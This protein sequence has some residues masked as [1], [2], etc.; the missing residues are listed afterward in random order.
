MNGF[1]GMVSFEIFSEGKHMNRFLD[2]L[3][4]ISPAISLGGV[5]S[6]ISVPAVTSHKDL[7]SEEQKSKGI[8]AALIR[9]S[10]GIEDSDDLI[11]DL[12][13]ALSKM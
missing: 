12:S 5:E 2:H 13:F 4:I 3:K 7:S 9:L 6:L 10:V 11:E 1:G 8:T